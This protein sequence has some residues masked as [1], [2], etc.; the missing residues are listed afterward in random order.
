MMY[1]AYV[2]GCGVVVAEL[3]LNWNCPPP[4]KVTMY[5]C[6]R[7]LSTPL[8]LIE[9]G[10]EKRKFFIHIKNKLSVLNG[11]LRAGEQSLLTC[12]LTTC[13]L[14]VSFVDNRSMTEYHQTEVS[15]LNRQ[16]RSICR[17]W[18]KGTKFPQSHPHNIVVIAFSR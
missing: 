17:Y 10:P 3:K 5:V 4:C 8:K 2:H 6:G 11:Q 16:T 15:K 12:P 13:K 14:L 18:V 7:F 9:S 1:V